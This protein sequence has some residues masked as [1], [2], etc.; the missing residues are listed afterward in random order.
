M[1]K[2]KLIALMLVETFIALSLGFVGPIYAIYFEKISDNLYFVPILIG[3][4]WIFVGFLEPIF[5]KHIDKIGKKKG[6]VIGCILTSIA[7]F[8]YPIA[9]NL[10]TIFIAQIIAAIGYSIEMPSYYS[11]MAEITNKEKRGSEIGKLDGWFNI[12]YGVSAIL[13]AIIIYHFA[14]ESIFYL[15]GCFYLIA[16]LFALRL[17][18]DI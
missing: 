8:L 1:K 9:S 12:M 3:I 18:D 7:I 14:L 11:L 4:Y 16:S 2:E 15:A 17:I 10:L 13:S 6:Y 5:G